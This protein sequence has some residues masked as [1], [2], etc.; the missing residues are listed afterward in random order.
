LLDSGSKE[1]LSGHKEDFI[2]YEE[3]SVSEAFAYRAVTGKR[4]VCRGRGLVLVQGKD[5][6]GATNSVPVEAW[7]SLNM[8]GR[9]LSIC[10]LAKE[11]ELY[12]NVKTECVND[13][14]GDVFGCADVS[15]GVPCLIGSVPETRSKPINTKPAITKPTITNVQQLYQFS[16]DQRIVELSDDEED[17]SDIYEYYT[18]DEADDSS[19]TDDESS[20]DE[21]SNKHDGITFRALSTREDTARVTE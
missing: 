4:V 19:L 20:D 17:L 14:Y 21:K 12:Y 5:R 10:K 1:T 3:V 6:Q 11:Y 16:N 13:K 2:K 8:D 9:I 7:F 15:S 18:H